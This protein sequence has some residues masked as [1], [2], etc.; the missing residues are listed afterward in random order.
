M[1]K[2]IYYVLSTVI[3][4]SMIGIGLIGC[5]PTE[6]YVMPTNPQARVCIAQCDNSK[7]Q[8]EELVSMKYQDCLSHKTKYQICI[9]DDSQC[10]S[11]YDSCFKVCGGTIEQSK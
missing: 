9:N 8:C 4:S 10:T 11:Q 2:T 6:N 5:S 3:L 7:N 1:K